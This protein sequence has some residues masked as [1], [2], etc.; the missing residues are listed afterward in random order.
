MTE[1]LK[2]QK[3]IQKLLRRP[4]EMTPQR[5][6]LILTKLKMIEISWHLLVKSRVG[7][8]VN[9]LRKATKYPEVQRKGKLLL[10][11]WKALA[12]Q[13]WSGVVNQV[14]HHAASLNATE[15]RESRKAKKKVSTDRVSGSETVQRLVAH[16][17]PK[18]GKNTAIESQGWS[19]QI[20]DGLKLKFTKKGLS[21]DKHQGESKS[22]SKRSL[23]ALTSK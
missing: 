6:I 2:I 22:G 13:G 14:N 1:V 21:K 18:T 10:K 9:D 5:G 23:S 20:M 15:K 16:E 17:Q 11:S 12:P 19:V 8:T 7:H 3:E 4:E